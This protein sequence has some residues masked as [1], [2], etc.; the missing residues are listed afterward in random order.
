MALNAASLDLLAATVDDLED[1]LKSR[2]RATALR[3]FLIEERPKALPAR[4]SGVAREVWARLLEAS[5]FLPHW[6]EVSRATSADGTIKLALSFADATIETVLIPGRGRS[7][8]CVSS[9]AGCSRRC[10]FCATARLGFGRNLRAGE[11]VVQYLVA[12][13]A[14]N[15]KSPPRNVVFMGM[16][17]PLDNLSEVLAAV[18]SLTDVFPGISPRHVTVSTAGVVPPMKLFLAESE[19]S[20]ALSLN[21]TTDEVRTRVMPHNAQ[22]PIEALLAV[23]REDGA[24]HP[25]RRS[26]IEYVLL[27][28]V[29]DTAQDARRLGVL[30]RGL[31]A[32]VNVIPHNPFPESAYA[33]PTRAATLRFQEQLRARDVKSIVRWPRGAD[34]AGACGQ[35][36]LREVERTDS[37]ILA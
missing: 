22:W 4:F 13:A 8:V 18:R 25:K 26:F 36:A 32:Q 30:L 17:E 31:N 15:P 12:A 27:A 16:G 35:L 1:P 7:T 2:T 34:I 33:A 19:A 23:L 29:N 21:A 3:R 37:S 20:L 9:Q 24:R 28:G 6:R 10:D 14:A 5:A 11:I